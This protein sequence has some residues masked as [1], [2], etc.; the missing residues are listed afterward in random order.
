LNPTTATWPGR[1]CVPNTTPLMWSLI[2]ALQVRLQGITVAN[3]CRTDIGNSI[4][5]ERD[6]FDDA[7]EHAVIYT[8]H[9]GDGQGNTG[10]RRVR[11]LELSIEPS[12]PTTIAADGSSNAHQRMHEIIADI[13]DALASPDAVSVSG[14][15]NV[16]V[17]EVTVVDEPN[18]MAVIAASIITTVE[19][20]LP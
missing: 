14:V 15:L 7:A 9:I 12:V 11:Q 16:K 3:G 6:Q 20:I 5:V 1:C 4:G 13:E 17:T 18:G 2:E 19:V 10:P 8:T